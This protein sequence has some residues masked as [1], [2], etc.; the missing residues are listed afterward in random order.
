MT[1]KPRTRMLRVSERLWD[2][3]MRMKLDLKK[4]SIDSLLIDIL[5]LGENPTSKESKE[6]VQEIKKEEKHL[7]AG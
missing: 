2:K 4:D 6:L 1:G 7:A 5:K 3:L